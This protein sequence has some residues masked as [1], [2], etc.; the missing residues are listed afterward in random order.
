MDLFCE[1]ERCSALIPIK[2]LRLNDDTCIS[3]RRA[4]LVPYL[5]GKY[6]ISHLEDKAPF[7]ANELKRQCLQDI[8]L[9]LWEAFKK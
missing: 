4:W 8:E 3:G 9:P 2:R 6:G 7:L 5:Q 1:R